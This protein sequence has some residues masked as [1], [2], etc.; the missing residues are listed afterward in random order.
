M[1]SKNSI[2]GKVRIFIDSQ[3]ANK[4]DVVYLSESWSEKEETLFR[5]MLIQGG[6]FGIQGKKFYII[7]EERFF[8]NDGSKDEIIKFDE[9]G[10]P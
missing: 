5:K 4:D 6:N 2:R 3:Q 8:R 1:L 9:D 7:P 10:N